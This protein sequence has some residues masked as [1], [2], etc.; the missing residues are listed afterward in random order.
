MTALICV[1]IFSVGILRDVTREQL[2]DVTDKATGVLW[3]PPPYV[4][5]PCIMTDTEAYHFY[6][7]H[8]P[9]MWGD[10]DPQR[11]MAGR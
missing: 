7:R 8:D 10:Y 3:Y 1:V 4:V 9:Q 6:A 2:R 5:F 11:G